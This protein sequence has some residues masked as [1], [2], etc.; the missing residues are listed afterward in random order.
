MVWAD[1]DDDMPDGDSLKRAFWT[2]AQKAGISKS[3]FDA[4]VFVFAKDR[5]ENWIEFLETGQTDES[6]E[7]ERVKYPKQASDAAKKLADRCR[8]NADGAMLPS[9]LAWS[10]QNWRVLCDRMA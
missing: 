9:S 10:C 5:I 2:V 7:G 1:L 3:D 8:T 4:V 6:K